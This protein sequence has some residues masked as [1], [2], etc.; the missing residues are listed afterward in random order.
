[1]NWET[2]EEYFTR[3]EKLP[4]SKLGNINYPKPNRYR[5]KLEAALDLS[6]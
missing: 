6:N 1:M 2:Q 4:L 5:D 3:K